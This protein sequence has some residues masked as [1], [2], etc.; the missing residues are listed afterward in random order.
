MYDFKG[1]LT[2]LVTPFINGGLDKKSFEKL[3]TAQLDAGIEGLVVNGTTAESPT[4]SVNET[5]SLLELT[6]KLVDGK[7]PVVLGTGTNSTQSTIENTKRAQELGADAALVVVPYYNKPPQEGI[8]AH[9]KA[10]AA[11]CPIPQILYNIP[12]RTVVS[13]DV[14]TA[15]ELSHIS[16]IIGIKDG[17]GDPNLAAELRSQCQKDFVIL[18]GDDES[19]MDFISK[20]GDGVISVISHLI[21]SEMVRLSGLIRT[22][23]IQEGLTAYRD[24]L[25]LNLGLS[26]STNP[27]PV[28][29]ALQIMNV[30]S[31]GEVRSP[32]V[33]LNEEFST[34]LKGVLSNHDLIEL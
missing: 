28:K 30:I 1:V 9:F 6:L 8:L 20:G 7:I 12:G 10:V 2:A 16:N 27:I 25:P 15:A 32:L 23:K 18:S 5:E 3:V 22:G 13:L 11:S 14:S 33:E 31:T 19:C 29:K 21:P 26:I 34:Q 24:L 4:L 17:S